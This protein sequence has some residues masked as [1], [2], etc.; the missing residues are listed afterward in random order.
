MSYCIGMDLGT[1]A[2]KMTLVNEEGQVI[3]TK[4]K[5]YPLILSKPG[6]AEQDPTNWVNALKEGLKEF[7]RMYSDIKGLVIDGQMHGLVALDK[8]FDIIRPCILWNDTRSQK[9]CDVLNQNS[10]FLL[11]ETGNIAFPGFT[12]PKI[13]WMKENEPELYEKIRYVMLPKDYL[14]FVL[15]GNLY[16]DY[17]DAA[18]TLALDVKNRCWSEKMIGLI[19]LDMECF[20]KIVE[21]GENLGEMKDELRKELGFG[22]KVFIYQGAADNAAA[23]ISNGVIG[24]GECSLSLGTSG[25]IYIASKKYSYCPNGAIHSFLSGNKSYCLLGCMLSAAS[26]LKWFNDNILENKDYSKYQDEI[27]EKDLGENSLYFLP[28]L[29]GERSP[30]N[31]ADAKGA[32]IGLTM[33]TSRKE[34]TQAVLEGVAFALKDSMAVIEEMGIKVS[35]ACLTGGGSKSSLWR[36]ILSAVLN[37]PLH[38]LS[39]SY[40]PSY[41][42]AVVGLVSMG[43][44][45]SLEEFKHSHLQVKE[46]IYPNQELVKKYNEKYQ[47]YKKLY[48]ALKGLF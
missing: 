9:Q 13:L 29:M 14:N 39:S 46:T 25:T 47:H 7:A 33:S 4:T 10:D 18:G 45:P 24:D 30:I 15:T 27:E 28:Y 21:T 12:L 43:C 40:G 35:E 16:T 44:F 11:K 19:G 2:L 34:M 26:C 37:L 31:D 36:E 8:D 20:P 5:E 22:N 17:S 42:M 3:E 1:S 41:G 23:A 6:Y 32:F 48:P 38:M